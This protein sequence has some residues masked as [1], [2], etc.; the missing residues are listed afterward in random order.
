MKIG[1]SVGL[2]VYISVGAKVVRGNN[3][4][5]DSDMDAKSR[6]GNSEVVG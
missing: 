2:D 4:R 5:I 1:N 6:S 3:S